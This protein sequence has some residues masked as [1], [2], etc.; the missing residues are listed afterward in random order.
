MTVDDTRP[1]IFHSVE[2]GGKYFRAGDLIKFKQR[3]IVYAK[4]VAFQTVPL[5]PNEREHYGG[6]KMIYIRQ[7][8]E[9]FTSKREVGNYLSPCLFRMIYLL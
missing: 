2:F 8:E 9:V 6:G 3:E 4:I 7:P 1:A 5:G